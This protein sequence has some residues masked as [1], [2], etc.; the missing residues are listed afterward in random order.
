MTPAEQILEL[1]DAANRYAS[2]LASANF[3][4]MRINAIAKRADQIK[5]TIN[6]RTRLSDEECKPIENEMRE[7]NLAIRDM[8]TDFGVAMD[9]LEAAALR[10]AEC[11]Q[12]AI[13]LMSMLAFAPTD[14]PRV[15]ALEESPTQPKS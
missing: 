9:E 8:T 14:L 3:L 10:R 6:G 5:A 13:P 1:S 12:R 2:A 11:A 15:V 4:G 7:I